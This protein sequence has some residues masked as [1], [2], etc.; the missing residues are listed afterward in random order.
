MLFFDSTI[1]IVSHKKS[2][3][4]VI[5]FFSLPFPSNVSFFHLVCNFHS[6]SSTSLPY[7]TFCNCGAVI[8]ACASLAITEEHLR[9]QSHKRLHHVQTC[10]PAPNETTAGFLHLPAQNV[11]HLRPRSEEESRACPV[12]ARVCTSVSGEG[13]LQTCHPSAAGQARGQ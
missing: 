1:H 7:L 6:F 2:Y 5:L 9:R 12:S 3:Q 4:N 13:C 8:T 11:P 10:G